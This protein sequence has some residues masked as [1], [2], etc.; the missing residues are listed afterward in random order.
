MKRLFFLLLTP[1]ATVLLLAISA[2]TGTASAATTANTLTT[3][4]NVQEPLFTVANA[5]TTMQNFPAV[6]NGG[7]LARKGFNRLIINGQ[8]FSFRDTNRF[9][10]DPAV[11]LR[12][13]KGLRMEKAAIGLGVGC[14]A[15]L[16]SGMMMYATGFL[17][18]YSVEEGADYA[19]IL[20]RA[21]K[22]GTAGLFMA[23]TSGAMGATSIA[24]GITGAVT[25]KRAIRSY[26]SAYTPRAQLGL[27]VTPG[28]LGMQLTF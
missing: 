16:I 2:A 19:A 23:I 7:E 6:N 4:A 14:A 15:F 20:R 27:A 5:H 21:H 25:V 28:G 11:V 8:K 10:D 17:T 9:I 12:L 1:M 13:Q 24:L 22:I 3:T 18:A 26:N